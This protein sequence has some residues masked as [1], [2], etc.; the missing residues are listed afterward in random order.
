MA[1]RTRKVNHQ[2][3]SG[4]HE[5]FGDNVQVI[6]DPTGF[7]LWVSPMEPGSTHDITAVRE[8]CLGALHPVAATGIPTLADK[9]YQ[10]AGIGIRTPIKDGNLGVDNRA[11]NGLLTG[12]RAIG[13]RAN[14]LLTQR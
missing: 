14:A 4:K 5:R 6:A 7:P 13:E 3:Y 11:Y 1:E 12:T 2:W 8:H 10:G 9:G